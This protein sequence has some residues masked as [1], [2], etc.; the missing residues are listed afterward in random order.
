MIR[1]YTEKDMEN[2]LALFD[3]NVP[4]FF[5]QSEKDGFIY[6]LNHE[7]EDYYIIEQEQKI[8]GCG[9]I[10]YFLK[11]AQAT[12]SWDIIHPEYQGKGL[13]RQLTTFRLDILLQNQKV[14]EIIVRTSQFTYPF[15]EKMGFYLISTEQNYWA[16]GID[17]YY[18]TREN[19]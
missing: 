16:P 3:R 14:K 5:A 9:G 17:L 12:I 6:F 18:M 7:K 2:V 13:G 19:S 10:N 1:E 11:D 15:Y 8:L 4:D